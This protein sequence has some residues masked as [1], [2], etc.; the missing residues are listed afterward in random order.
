MESSRLAIIDAHH[1]FWDLERNYHPWLCDV[2]P[3]TFRYG[4]YSA[5]RRSYFPEDYLADTR[6]FRIVGS[7]HMETVWLQDIIRREGLPTAMV[8]QAWLDRDDVAE[9]LTAHAA[10]SNVRGVRHKPK[11][12][13]DPRSVNPGAPGSM[14]DDRWRTGYALLHRHGFS[15]DL[16][17]PYWHLP[18]AAALAREFPDTRLILN[19][20]GLPADRSEEG[21]K[22]WHRA[23]AT[24]ADEPNVAVKISGI[25]VPG[26]AWTVDSNRWIVLET[27]AMFGVERCMFA[28]NFPVDGL[29]ASFATIFGGFMAMVED[30]PEEE[31]RMLFHDNAVRI[32]RL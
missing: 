24:L 20:T 29:M 5:I 11:A 27:I 30:L 28:S 2:P 14:G 8:A 32:Y 12:A 25:G 13:D 16:Q 17:T 9:V 31:Q 1:H 15:F 6:D 4:D 19:H 21:L 22:A 26:A 10:F 3:I 23:M 7:V 18:E